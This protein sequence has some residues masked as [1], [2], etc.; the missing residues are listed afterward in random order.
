[1][2]LSPAQTAALEAIRTAF[3]EA[4]AKEVT[5]WG[6]H[7]E[8]VELPTG[9]GRLTWQALERAGRIISRLDRHESEQ[10]CRGAYG[11]WIGGPTTSHYN[12]IRVRPI[13]Q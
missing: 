9:I 2:K 8:W 5:R 1:M 6:Q 7:I 12:Q 11:K 13:T 10:L 3:A 4:D